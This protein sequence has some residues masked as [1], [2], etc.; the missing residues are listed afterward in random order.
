MNRSVLFK[1]FQV[2]RPPPDARCRRFRE[3]FA[4]YDRSLQLIT[5]YGTFLRVF[6]EGCFP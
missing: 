5:V 6:P 1:C 2:V 4:G 3:A